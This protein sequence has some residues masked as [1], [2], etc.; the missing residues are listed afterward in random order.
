[1]LTPL[2]RLLPFAV[3]D[4]PR[5]MAID[6]WMLLQAEQGAASL[7]FYAWRPATLSLG[8]FQP[9]SDRLADAHLASLPWVRRS[10]GGAALVHDHET[11]YA[12]ALP[13]GL[14]WQAGEPWL[15]RM[16]RIV[17]DALFSLGVPHGVE[18]VLE[19][20]ILGNVLCFQKQTAGDL[21]IGGRKIVGSA[22]RKHRRCLLQHGSILLRRSGFTPGLDGLGELTG[23]VIDA[24]AMADATTRSFVADTGWSV[25]PASWS[26]HD[27]MKIEKIVREKYASD[28]WN[29]KR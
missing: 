29:E 11:T 5:N 19:E 12:L 26:E 18:P 7:R 8:Y 2:I 24:S 25:E 6:E 21:V 20:K 16:H 28:A 14:P 10:S 4:G 23:N 27:L 3:A 1:M 22:Q 13:P 17:R 15:R 9:T